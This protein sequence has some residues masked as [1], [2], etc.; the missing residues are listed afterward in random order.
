MRGAKQPVMDLRHSSS[1]MSVSDP[2]GERM[3]FI[4]IRHYS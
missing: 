3:V 1:P 2:G 4:P